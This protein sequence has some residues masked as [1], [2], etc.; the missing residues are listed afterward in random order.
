[1][2]FE[3]GQVRL[4]GNHKCL[5]ADRNDLNTLSFEGVT[6]YCE[7]VLLNKPAADTQGH[8]PHVRILAGMNVVIP[9]LAQG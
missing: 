6:T 2:I 8:K 4:V 9:Y 1:M 5:S 3:R 7:A